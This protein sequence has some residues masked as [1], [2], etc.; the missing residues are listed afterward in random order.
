[1]STEST[2]NP[3]IIIAIILSSL[4]KKKYTQNY[5]Q[6]FYW[7]KIWLYEKKSFVNFE[8]NTL[9]F[10]FFA[11]I[12]S[13]STCMLLGWQNYV[14]F[15]ICWSRWGCQYRC[16]VCSTSTMCY[17]FS[18]VVVVRRP[19]DHRTSFLVEYGIMLS[20]MTFFSRFSSCTTSYA[21]LLLLNLINHFR[22]SKINKVMSVPCLSW[23]TASQAIEK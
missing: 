15:A 5:R 3:T 11:T 21:P 14:E 17:S 18:K 6:K 7:N 19:G 2:K 20:A 4:S 23:Q 1:M 10:I 22:W 13:R 16:D 8:D 12:L 9:N